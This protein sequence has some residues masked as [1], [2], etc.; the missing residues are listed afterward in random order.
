[1]VDMTIFWQHY[2]RIVPYLMPG[3]P[4]PELERSQTPS[5]RD[6]LDLLV[7]CIM[8]ASCH[9]SCPMTASDEE[10]LGPAALVK[11]NRFV[12]DSRD[13][14]QEQRLQMVA[15]EHGVWRC[16]TVFNCSIACPKDVDPAGSIAHLKRAA[17][18]HFLLKPSK[19]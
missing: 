18:R 19:R 9:A 3:D 17:T 4:P 12:V 11:A 6:R 16:H 8:C 14:A 7:D 15:D 10:Y 5:E 13:S 2:R 1:V